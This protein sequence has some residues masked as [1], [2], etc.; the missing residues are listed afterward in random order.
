MDSKLHPE[1]SAPAP[2]FG[3]LVSLGATLLTLV[4]L[5]ALTHVA[6]AAPP[7]SNAARGA[8]SADVHTV[9][10]AGPPDCD[11]STVQA[12]VDAAGQG[13][14]IKVAHGTY[15]DL[16][17][18]PAPAG[19]WGPEV[20]TQVVYISQ[21]VTI[22]GGYTTTNGFADPPDPQAHPSTL[23][24]GGQGRVLF[25]SGAISPT[26]EG[27]RLIGGDARGL[28]GDLFSEQGGG[29]VY[30][31]SASATI[32][33]TEILSNTAGP[34]GSGGG[35]SLIRS[36]AILQ[37]NSIHDNSAGSHGGGAHLWMSPATLRDNVITANSVITYGGGLTLVSSNAV[38]E[39]NQFESNAAGWGGGIY[40][41]S[42]D[43]TLVRNTF[44]GHSTNA[45]GGLYLGYAG[46]IGTTT[47]MSNTF[48]A[49]T[50]GWGGGMLLIYAPVDIVG[51]LIADNS[52]LVGGGIWVFSSDTHFIGNTFTGN[53]ASQNG[54]GIYIYVSTDPVLT[55]NTFS[56]N[57]AGL[58]GALHAIESPALLTG[59]S[60]ATNTADTG[61]GIVMEHSACRL[62]NN[63]VTSNVAHL[64]G[65]G[66]L[67]V[68]SDALLANTIVAGNEAGQLGDGLYTAG[69]AARLVHSTL[70]LNGGSDGTGIHVTA[71][72]L[73]PGTLVL[74]DTI[75][76]SHTTGIHV[77][78][79]SS[80]TLEATVWGNA[81]DWAGEG[82][83]MTGTVSLWGPPA[84]VDPGKLD[85]HIGRASVAVDSGLY[86][87]IAE[88]IDGDPRPTGSG[89]D[90]GADEFTA[91]LTA[92]KTASPE[93]VFAGSPLTYTL[94]VTNTGFVTLTATV[95]DH[96]PEQVTPAGPLTWTALLAP[97][98]VWT[99]TV[100]V[101]TQ[102]GY[103]GPLT[104]VIQ[105]QTL[106]G[107]MGAHTL[108]VTVE[109]LRQHYLP[110]VMRHH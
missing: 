105:V 1:T 92:R 106:E 91:S 19:Y 85:F 98:A 7:D 33:G 18:R 68:D 36:D 31:W 110:L 75:L 22:R 38:V 87:G 69:S 42:S 16:A 48:E 70:A 10:T 24:A 55:G 95:I 44:R 43:P 53:E 28:G 64:N 12:A 59:N 32:S 74:T 50:A 56:G 21:T 23:D 103:S 97:N 25:I 72:D 65:G 47:V 93:Q 96:L 61:G 20:V 2:R 57:V 46:W 49:N 15:T 13:D 109:P 82:T 3:L 79:G 11:F 108:I 4:V 78:Q 6:L 14:L 81:S 5:V 71:S 94:C 102:P 37:G 41:D 35:L 66:L 60:F 104:N 86:A 90:I 84:F 34:Q 80:A 88:D 26:V 107:A 89:V 30:V 54:G 62:F 40:S 58:G 39:G 73:S 100:A 77:D 29:G 76:V 45:G 27:F 67:L 83:I 8:A 99:T 101:T 63:T 17:V 9:C 52:A 51:N